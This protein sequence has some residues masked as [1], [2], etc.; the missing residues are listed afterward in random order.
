[1]GG[2]FRASLVPCVDAARKCV[3]DLGL[4]T[5]VVQI[6]TRQWSGLVGAGLPDDGLQL[7]AGIQSE[8]SL[9][10]IDPQPVVSKPHPRLVAADP[11]KYADGDRIISKISRA[12]TLADFPDAPRGGGGE[13]TERYF[14]IDGDPYRMVRE[15]QIE[16]FE[17][18]VHVRRMRRR[19]A[20]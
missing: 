6:T 11:G 20:I 8:T 9:V 18:I 2:D 1:M 14:L 10:V 5:E 13:A 4:R 16:N 15:P 17:W 3:E 19:P 7:G 12:Y